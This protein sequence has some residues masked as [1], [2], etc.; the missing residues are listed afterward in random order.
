MEF[1]TPRRREEV[2]ASAQP[3]SGWRIGR[4]A[5]YSEY[6]GWHLLGWLVQDVTGEPLREHL[7]STVL[8][9][10]GLQHTWIGMT[11]HQFRGALPNLGLNHEFRNGHMFPMIAE[12][13]ERLA[14]ETNPAHGGYTTARDLARFYEG[15]VNRVSGS[16]SDALAPPATLIEFCS[17]ARPSTYDVV[18]GR[19]CEF[20]LGLMTVLT[21]HDFSDACSA[22]AF[23]HSGN[24]G[25]SF[26]FADPEHHLSVGVVFNGLTTGDAALLRR[27]LLVQAIYDD[28][29]LTSGRD[30]RTPSIGATSDEVRRQRTC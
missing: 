5:G 22:S 2:V 3:P 4:D 15:I 21:D 12:R 28:L 6:V 29:G 11:S 26:G 25:S 24:V 17:T 23:G 30:T 27:R 7:R 8:D 18:L 19:K 9:P 13:S 1:L 20:G 16:G 14:C 10:L